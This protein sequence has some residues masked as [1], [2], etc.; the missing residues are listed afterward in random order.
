MNNKTSPHNSYKT[1]TSGYLPN[2][3]INDFNNQG[4]FFDRIGEFIIITIAEKMDM[5]NDFFIKHNL[6]ALEW[7]LNAIINKNK[8]LFK[9]NKL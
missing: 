4:Y 1:I 7:K 8:F 9:K 3:A 2:G 6:C 5:T